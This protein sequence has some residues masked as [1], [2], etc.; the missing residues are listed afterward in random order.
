MTIYGW[1]MSHYDWDRGLTAAEVRA[2][3]GDISFMTHKIG[4]GGS[5][6]DHRFDDFWRA[7]KGLRPAVLLG[8]YYVLH[9]GGA[10]S[11]ADR[12]LSLLDRLAPSWRS[13]PFIL[14]VDAEKFSYMSREPNRSECKQFCDRLVAKTGGEFRP[15]LYAPKW[16]Y[17]DRMAGVGYPLWASSYGS[18]PA[19][20]FRAAYPGDGSSR[21]GGYSGQTPV[22][23]QYGSKTRIGSQGTCDANAYRGTL[24]ELVR[25]VYPEGDDDVSWSEKLPETSSTKARFGAGQKPASTY[26]MLAAIYAF[27]A[28][29]AAQ[30]TLRATAGDDAD[31][32]VAEIRAQGE[33]TRAALLA[34]VTEQAPTLAA[35]VVGRLGADVTAAEIGEALAVELAAMLA[36]TTAVDGGV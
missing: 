9:P 5:Y 14:Q 34:A 6:T 18:N 15:I 22:I 17:A 33:Q 23:L 2:V 21:W 11:Q 27:D 35:A 7:A 19:T 36:G 28:A 16:V 29:K 24:A 1:D 25:L 12:F 4:E 10:A 3:A 13:G 26:L 8:A 32:I 30:A 20:G 31:T